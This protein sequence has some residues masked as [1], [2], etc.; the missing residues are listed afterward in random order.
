MHTSAKFKGRATS[1]CK[2]SNEKNTPKK[3]M[4]VEK[5]YKEGRGGEASITWELIL[6]KN[7]MQHFYGHLV[8]SCTYFLPTCWRMLHMCA[9]YLIEV[10]GPW[11]RY[12]RPTTWKRSPCLISLLRFFQ[13]AVRHR[14]TE[15]PFL[16]NTCHE[17]LTT[18]YQWSSSALSNYF[19]SKWSFLWL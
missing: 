17:N 14:V 2:L 11:Q 10:H 5:I 7:A 18:I 6:A 16:F 13:T 9:F 1:V 8:I 4:L 19:A 15:A 12:I 3:K